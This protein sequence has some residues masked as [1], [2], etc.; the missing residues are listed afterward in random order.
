LLLSGLITLSFTLIVDIDRPTAG[1]LRE[2][3]GALIDLHEFLKS[4]PAPAPI[5]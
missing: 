5:K 3:Q 1:L 4:Y 2:D